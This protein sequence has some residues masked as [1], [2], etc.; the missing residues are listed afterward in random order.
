M[1]FFLLSILGPLPWADMLPKRLV[2]RHECTQVC[3]GFLHLF[4]TSSNVQ[5]NRDNQNRLR[6]SNACMPQQP[7]AH[8]HVG[9]VNRRG[10]PRGLKIT[11]VS[12]ASVPRPFQAKA[13][14]R[15]PG[16]VGREGIP[17]CEEGGR[18]RGQGGNPTNPASFSLGVERC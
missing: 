2:L 12:I 1:C 16:T 10:S 15:V 8:A 3:K 18:V 5:P 9:R 7:L 4:C 6:D 14:H 13:W 17:L 11:T